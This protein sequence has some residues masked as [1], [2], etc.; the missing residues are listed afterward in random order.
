MSLLSKTQL[1]ELIEEGVIIASHSQVN[2]S[3]ID[4]TLHNLIQIESSLG[5]S[6]PPVDLYPQDGIT[7]K[8]SI[9]LTPLDMSLNNYPQLKINCGYILRPDE[10]ILASTNEIFNLP[11]NISA[12]YKLKSTQARNAMEHLNAGFC[13]P[14]WNNSK[15]TLELKNVSRYHKLIIRP[16]MP[17]GQIVFFR[18]EVSV[19]SNESYAVRGQ[20]NNQTQVTLSKGLR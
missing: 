17:C 16:N 15:L 12:E 13:D 8:Q 1:H 4:L 19:P 11:D 2:G 20:Y 10:F 14:G 5:L 7:P 6:N 18:H 3:S 9:L